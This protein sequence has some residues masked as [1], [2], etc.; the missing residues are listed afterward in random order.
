MSD[1]EVAAARSQLFLAALDLHREFLSHV[2]KEVRQSLHGAKDVVS[3]DA[4][5]TL[6]PAAVADAWRALFF[7]VPVVSTTFASFATMFRGFGA[8][9]ARTISLR[10]LCSRRPRL[11]VSDSG[12]VV[13]SP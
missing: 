9:A 11:A 6:D 10:L 1:W 5:R 13:D 3:G 2:P 4:P 12:W 7:L 8:E